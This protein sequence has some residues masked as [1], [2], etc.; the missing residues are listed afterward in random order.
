MSRVISAD[1]HVLMVDLD[2]NKRKT[3]HEVHA[4]IAYLV[5]QGSN[6]HDQTEGVPLAFDILEGLC[7]FVGVA[8]EAV[9]KAC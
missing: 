4:N 8:F 3:R 5:I 7:H 9:H 1:V 2:T 6:L